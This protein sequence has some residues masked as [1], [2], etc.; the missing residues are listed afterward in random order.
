MQ[1]LEESISDDQSIQNMEYLKNYIK[2][3]YANRDMK[4]LLDVALK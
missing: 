2:L 4:K 3:L 1:M